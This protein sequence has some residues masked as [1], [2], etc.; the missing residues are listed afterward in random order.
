[1]SRE[2]PRLTGAAAV[3]TP[4]PRSN[5][6]FAPCERELI[7]TFL[8]GPLAGRCFEFAAALMHPHR[9]VTLGRSTEC[10]VAVFDGQV[11]RQHCSISL[12]ANR[13]VLKDLG[14]SNGT[15]V[16]GERVGIAVLHGGEIVRLGKI[17]LRVEIALAERTL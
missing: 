6:A 16:D 8:S 15:F 10:D 17:E 3:E 9:R 7:L 2:E 13:V 12:E 5:E 14:S 1:M 11:S 4:P